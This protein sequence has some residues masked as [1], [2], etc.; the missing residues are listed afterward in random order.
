MTIWQF[1]WVAAAMTS[2]RLIGDP[3]RISTELK[4][5]VRDVES[6]AE[7]ANVHNL[8]IYEISS[9]GKVFWGN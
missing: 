5:H 8:T 9:R 4:M 3:R 1:A 7:A 6:P 2:S